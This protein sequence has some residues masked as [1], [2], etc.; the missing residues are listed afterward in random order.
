MGKIDLGLD[1][2]DT[3]N[4][5]VVKVILGVLIA[6]VGMSELLA[7]FDIEPWT[8]VKTFRS[9]IIMGIGLYIAFL[10]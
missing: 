3:S 4:K 8:I 5:G 7:M 6:I 10:R 2:I 9:A 1:K